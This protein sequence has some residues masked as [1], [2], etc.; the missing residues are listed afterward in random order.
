M[1]KVNEV[2]LTVNLK[3]LDNLSKIIANK[4]FSGMFIGLIGDLGTGKTQFTKF[5][6]KNLGGSEDEVTSP[7]FTLLN[8]Y[9][10]QK[11]KIYHFDLYRLNSIDELEEIGYEDFFYFKNSVIVV[12]WIDRIIAA[13]PDEYIILN[14]FYMDDSSEK[15]VIKIYYK[16]EKYNFINEIRGLKRWD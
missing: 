11:F 15:R 1:Q 2:R 8:E 12:E 13:I 7:T 5:L 16:G 4:C 9:E 14:F 10:T 3:D 6:V